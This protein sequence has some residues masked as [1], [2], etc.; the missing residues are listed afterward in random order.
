M[1]DVPRPSLN[2]QGVIGIKGFAIDSSILSRFFILSI[3]KYLYSQKVY[4]YHRK[5]Q[6]L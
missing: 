4:P 2:N 6:N 3:I 5:L 1:N